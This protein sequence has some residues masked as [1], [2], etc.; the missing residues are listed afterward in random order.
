MI[1]AELSYNP[2]LREMAVK[3]NG[4]PPHI[5][6]LVEK[7]QDCPL[8]DWVTEIPFIFHD[9]M[10]GYGFELDFCGTELDFDEVRNAFHM[11]AV[12]ESEV[13]IILKNA[14]ECREAKIDRIIE[15]LEWLE[16]NRFRHF[17][18]EQ[19][20]IE[21]HDL[22]DI[23]FVCIV[24]HG[25]VEKPVLKNITIEKVDNVG[26]LERTDL[27][28]TPILYCLSNDSISMLSRDLNFFKRRKDV[29][30]DQLFFCIGEGNNVQII[31]RLL[32]DHGISTP[33]IVS[34]INDDPVRKY[35]LIYPFTD[36]ISAVID[37]FR[38]VAD[39][40]TGI[41]DTENKFS[42]SKG[43]KTHE[44]LE[45]LAKSIYQ[46]EEADRQI[47]SEIKLEYPL[48]FGEHTKKLIDKISSW[49]KHKTKITDPQTA[50]KA[51]IEFNAALLGFLSDFGERIKETSNEYA[52]KTHE[53][54]R[55]CYALADPNNEF[56]EQIELSLDSLE[57]GFTDQTECLLEL[58]K[59]Q[60]VDPRNNRLMHLFRSNESGEQQEPVL[61][62]TY[63][64]QEWRDHMISEVLPAIRNLTQSRFQEL[65][66]YSSMLSK[67]Y[68]ERLQSLMKSQIA[69]RDSVTANLSEEEKNLQQDNEWVDNLIVRLNN[70]ERS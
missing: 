62:T 1:T 57:T 61:E 44:K 42:K 34:G 13:Q 27:T 65:T 38:G 67:V 28:H 68:H 12:S 23:D 51:A 58:K 33:R 18:F 63:Y 3:F 5:N 19:F 15:L 20:R 30:S 47:T 2:Y 45:E 41:L 11:Q 60:Y 29:T 9:E 14:L 55:A 56:V 43:D 40:L 52:Q 7:Y 37:V 46:I 32:N 22:V 50:R 39:N 21:H 59:E 48:E 31:K 4:Q 69:Q 53:L 64:Y 66:E 36:Y 8:Q 35:M 70:I 54:I 17:D 25:D 16:N 10:N 49:E 6:S 24:L 26:E